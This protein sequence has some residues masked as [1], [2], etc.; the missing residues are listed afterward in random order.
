MKVVVTTKD[1]CEEAKRYLESE[2]FEVALRNRLGIGAG[3]PDDVLYPVVEDADA[4]IAGT[5]TY[6]PELLA[7]LR[8]LK[9]ICRNG[10]GYDAINL[11]ALRKEGIGL[12]RTKGFVEGAVAEQVMAYILYFAR[13]VDL[14]S[15]DMH[16]H[17]WNSRLMPGAKNHTI[18][19]VGFGGI[20][21]EVAKRA[22]PFGMKVIYFI[23]IRLMMR[24][25]ACKAFRW[26]S[27]SKKAITLSLRFRLRI[28]RSI[29][30]T[31]N[32]LLR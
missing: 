22:V 12:T 17:C 7:R 13:R 25:T 6:R 31:R 27:S 5:E 2:G 32:A 20:G 3:A 24:L 9:L 1:F 19:L 15:A 14:Q 29:F 18:G 28:R 4:I 8:N 11:D 21:T 10:I 16:D 30:L 26:K 23:R